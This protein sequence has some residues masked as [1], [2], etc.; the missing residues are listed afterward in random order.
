MTGVTGDSATRTGS[1]KKDDAPANPVRQPC[2]NT[3][4]LTG[5][6]PDDVIRAMIGHAYAVV[7]CRLPKRAQRELSGSTA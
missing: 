2:F 5:S 7:V 3:V 1:A 6:A 4:R